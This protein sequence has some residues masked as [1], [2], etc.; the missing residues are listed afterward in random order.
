[1]SARIPKQV[2]LTLLI[3]SAFFFGWKV[4]TLPLTNWDEGIYANVNLELFHSQ[5]WTKLTYFG[6][7]F[8]EKPPLQYWMTYPL[9]GILGPTELAVRL[10]SVLAGIAT[11]LLIALWAWQ[12]TKKVSIALMAG[13]MI[14]LGRYAI[15]HAFRTGDLDGLLT[16]CIT[17][18]LYGYWRSWKVPRWFFVWGIASA[19]AIMTKSLA[20]LVPVIIVGMDIVL[21]RGWRRIGWGNM[22][23]GIAVFIGLI[24]PWHII[25]TQ[26]FGAAFW[27][28]YIG[29]NI[30]DRSTSSL[31]T[32]TP[33][34]W[35]LGIIHDRFF[36]FS[37]ALPLGVVTAMWG[38][39]KRHDDLLRL[40][41]LW[42]AVVLTLF[43]VIQTRR[44]WYILPFYPAAAMLLALQAH[45]WWSERQ[46]RW[47]QAAVI[48]SVAA[49]FI[50]MAGDKHLK[51]FLAHVPGS[52]VL[53]SWMFTHLLGQVF[54]GI[55]A[56]LIVLIL[57]LLWR[58]KFFWWKAFLGSIAVILVLESMFWTVQQLRS[59]PTTLPLKTIA[60][61]IQTERVLSID[62][63]GTK[64]KKEPAGY[65]YILRLDAHSTE[66]PAGQ[67]PR[68]P[69]FLTT[70]EVKN[71][72]LNTEGRVLERLGKFL[73]IDL[74]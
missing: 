32:K 65:F 18:A 22:W 64:L 72:P 60:D 1:M 41:L 62:L 8:L 10:W 54:I 17:L 3:A 53:H 36:P 69:L 12:A 70:N 25:E 74:R 37:Y 30:V 34:Y 35:Y 58:R 2:W 67:I 43:T 45:A 27:K 5:D 51:E 6:K 31:F 56:T 40:L 48:M 15:A 52:S 46:P 73:L 11:V 19:G 14:V 42:G 47:M 71:A 28:E 4:N 26:R 66:L 7:D 61:R 29:W 59:Y 24:A 9:F 38:W 23:W 21:T 49:M 63:A 20:G 50:R 16:F 44:E 68:T 55:G 33:W 57:V 13:A 39:R